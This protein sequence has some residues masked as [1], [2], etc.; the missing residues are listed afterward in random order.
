MPVHF[1][2]DAC[3]CINPPTD[4]YF[5]QKGISVWLID[6]SNT[7]SWHTE[8]NNNKNL[9]HRTIGLMFKNRELC[10]S[11]N[12]KVIWKKGGKNYRRAIFRDIEGSRDSCATHLKLSLKVKVLIFFSLRI[13][14]FC[15]KG[16]LFLL[17]NCHNTVG[18]KCS[19][20]LFGG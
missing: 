14:I 3:V 13:L 2:K 19:L 20:W 11:L 12:R 9:P 6:Y 1:T 4:R 16:N 5:G 17:T 10:V 15:I 18:K 8:V 7:A